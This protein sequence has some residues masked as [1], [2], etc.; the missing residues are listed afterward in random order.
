[1]DFNREI[2]QFEMS[3]GEFFAQ[4]AQKCL[5]SLTKCQFFAGSVRLFYKNT[6]IN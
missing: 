4:F 3:V 2:G 6:K 1:M 5:I